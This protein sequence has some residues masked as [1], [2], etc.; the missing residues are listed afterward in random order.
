MDTATIKL[1]AAVVAS[2]D[3]K[4]IK[5]SVTVRLVVFVSSLEELEDI[6]HISS[7]CLAPNSTL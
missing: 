5:G 4:F 1:T 6:Y 7:E 3:S 2:M